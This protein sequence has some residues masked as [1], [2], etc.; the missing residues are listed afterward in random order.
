VIETG[1]RF[2]L[3]PR[4]KHEPTLLAVDAE[5][6]Q[7][8]IKFL[9]LAI[10][11]AAACRA[12]AVSLW[13]GVPR[14]EVLP[15]QARLFLREGL[16]QVLDYA[17]KKHVIIALEPEPGMLIATVDDFKQL[18]LEFPALKIA[19]DTAIAWLTTKAIQKML[20]EK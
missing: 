7:K 20:C 2:L 8:R 10:D 4:R 12:E 9:K 16:K 15:E 19:L 13:A 18:K 6:R 17:Q 11:L 1:A 5:G 3:D 14:P